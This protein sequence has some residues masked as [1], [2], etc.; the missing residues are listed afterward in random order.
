MLRIAYDALPAGIQSRTTTFTITDRVG[1]STC[2]FNVIQKA[3][4]TGRKGDVNNDGFVD[5]NDVNILINIILDRDSADN[6]NGRALITDDNI[7]DIADV[8]ELVN[9]ILTQ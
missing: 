7:V 5:I 2:T 4:A 9:L 6:Y 8:N 3:A 1:A